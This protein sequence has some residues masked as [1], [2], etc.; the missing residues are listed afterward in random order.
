MLLLKLAAMA[1]SGKESG[2]DRSGIKMLDR[3]S[4]APLFSVIICAH[5]NE[6]RRLLKLAVGSVRRQTLSPFEIIVVI[7]HNEALK[8][9]LSEQLQGVRILS[10]ERTRGLSG[11]RNTGVNHA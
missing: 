11:A 7:D 8:A 1:G 9:S 3:V 6:R 2:P 10:N 4:E 5:S